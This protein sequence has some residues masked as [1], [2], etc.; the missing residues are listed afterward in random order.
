MS[1]RSCGRPR[2][3]SVVLPVLV[4][5]LLAL[6]SVLALPVRAAADGP[7][8]FSNTVSIAV[9]ATGSANQRGPASPYPSDLTV[10]G[11]AGAVTTVTVTLAD[12]THGA[13]ADV[14]ALLVAPGGRNLLLL[15]DVG[16]TGLQLVTATDATLTFD[17][18]ADGPVPAQVVVPSGSYRPTNENPGNA[19]DTFPAPAPTPSSQTTLAGAFTGIDPNGTWSLYVVD[20][21]V[22]E[23]GSIAGGWSL[24][25]T[26]ETAAE[27]T[28]TVVTTSDST[29]TPGEPVTFTATVSSDGR[30]VPAGGTVQF[31]DGST[32]LGGPRPVGAGGVAT[33]QTSSLTEGTHEIRATYS[34]ITGYLTSNGSV[35]Q[36][37]DNATVVTD[38][39]FCNPGAIVGPNQGQAVPYPSNIFV[40]GLSGQVT[41]VSAS[42]RGVSHTEPQDLDVLLSGPTPATNVILLSDAGGQA[43]VSDLDLVFDDEA[44]GAAPTPLTSGTFRPTDLDPDAQVDAFPAPAPSLSGAT[45]LSTFDGASAN[46]TWSLWVVDDATGDTG[47]ISD[48]WCLTITSQSPTTTVLTSTPNPSTFGA[49]VTLRATVTAGDDPVTTGTVQLSDG[50]TPLGVPVPVNGAGVA[51]L[52]TSGLTVGSHVIT[53]TYGGTATLAESDDDLT[54][55]VQKAL[56]TTDLTSSVN[57]SDVGETVIFTATVSADGQPVTAGSVQFAVDGTDA[58]GA[59]A[60]GSSGQVTFTTGALAAGTHAITAEY[61]GTATLASSDDD[62]DQVV[63]R[64]ATTTTVASSLNPSRVG[65][66]VT[67]TATVTAEGAPLSGGSVQFADGGTALGAPQP[68]AADGTATYPTAALAEGTHPITATFVTTP[69]YAESTSDPLAQVVGLVPTQ[70]V[71]V[72][73]VNPSTVGQLVT[74]TATVTADGG[75]TPAGFVQFRDGGSDLGAPV[76]LDAGGRADYPA[77]ALTAG[78]HVITA[79]FLAT[80][81]YATST[82]NAVTQRVDTIA[83]TTTVT[84][85]PDP[86]DPGQSVTFTA[87]VVSTGGPVGSGAV[88]FSVDGGPSG[89]PVAVLADGTASFS[90]ATLEP[91]AHTI[92]ATYSGDATYTTSQG[93][94]GHDVRPVAEAGGPYAVAEGGSLTLRA[95]D[96]TTDGVTYV[97]DLNGDGV[98][99]ATGANPT[100]TWAQLQSLGITDGLTPPVARTIRLRVTIDEVESA[101]SEGQLTV[102]NTA[103]DSV[104]TGDL[105][106]TVGEPFTVKVGANDPSSA[107]LAALFTYTVDW[108]DGSPVE[109]TVGP[110]DP[111]VT[112]TYATAG[113]FVAAF[114]AT[115]KDGGTGPGL[116]V[117][118]TVSARQTASP[119][120]QPRPTDDPDEDL[121]E[122]DTVV[123][124]LASTGS[125]VG[126]GALA[127][128]LGLL[129]AGG[130]LLL[131]ARRRGGRREG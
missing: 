127:A 55:V 103:P 58:G 106:A 45:A 71:L 26:T 36:R 57:P 30:P 113:V 37:V 82:S 69:T 13:L 63:A 116:T 7:T 128:G 56:T 66:E 79:V 59:V 126:L 121:D 46:G 47:S 96:D 40:T 118:V 86:S 32:D 61:S 97:W 107:D 19:A 50:G 104:V 12:V 43:Q 78:A 73:S 94:D 60:L 29:S 70:T 125:A 10:S 75:G 65:D 88:T 83:T 109:T 53:A 130:A 24:T 115:D 16:D 93:S 27:R 101:P 44:A 90:V 17:D 64:I 67:F 20:D 120:A 3:R 91:G 31:A 102:T 84:S 48:G 68:L 87:T 74:F 49:S 35:T 123:D 1:R 18:A 2:P 124:S 131:G 22:G 77:P 105:T 89:A 23:V 33:Y 4:G 11:L 129:G 51:S 95:G 62:L 14:D 80:A 119:T 9:P 111:P 85:A 112:H 39:T 25:V 41:E 52:T 28:E 42:L 76:P 99:D 21:N 5:L 108:G 6:G 98:G 8:T 38:T 92:T 54:Q 34:G 81:Q 117:A 122:G 100:L 110:A 72:S 15:S 114:A